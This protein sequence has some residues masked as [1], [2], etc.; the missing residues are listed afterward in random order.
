MILEEY[1]NLRKLNN[2]LVKSNRQDL[3][4]QLAKAST[5]NQLSSLSED[6]LIDPFKFKTEA[7][8]EQLEE[9]NIT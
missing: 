3:G 6:V 9:K 4:E 5:K 2:D 7:E 1:F 8:T